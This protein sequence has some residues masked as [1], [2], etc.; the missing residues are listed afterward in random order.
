MKNNVLVGILVL[1]IIIITGIYFFNQSSS[2]ETPGE[3]LY[4]YKVGDFQVITSTS[5]S[6]LDEESARITAE[7]AIEIF[8]EADY[9]FECLVFDSAEKRIDSRNGEEFWSVG[10]NCNEECSEIYINCGATVM[11]KNNYEVIIGFPNSVH[12]SKEEACIASG[13]NVVDMPCYCWTEGIED[14]PDFDFCTE[15]G[16]CACD[17]EGTDYVP[18]SKSIK[19]CECPE[20]KCFNGRSC[21]ST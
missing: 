8:D 16:L 19:I 1:I 5:F 9:K 7:E 20:G 2:E 11:I 10:F 4:G 6:D 12:I 15:T 17:P 18:Y 14:F 13:G 21:V 3:N